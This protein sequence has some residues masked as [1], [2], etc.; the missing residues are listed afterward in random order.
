MSRT[1]FA[2]PES[3]IV[4]STDGYFDVYPAVARTNGDKPAYRGRLTELDPEVRGFD[5]RLTV[6]P[7]SGALRDAVATWSG[8]NGAAAVRGDLGTS[9]YDPATAA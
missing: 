9:R 5:D 2:H 1:S 6:R 3:T 7:S 8:E 4:V